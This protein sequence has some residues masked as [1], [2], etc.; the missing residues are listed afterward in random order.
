[1]SGAID[2]ELAR[3]AADAVEVYRDPPPGVVAEII[4]GTLFTMPR[5]RPLHQ[6]AGGELYASLSPPFRRARGGP[7]G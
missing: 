4:A 7:G 5:P 2:P 1:M 3:L 6:S